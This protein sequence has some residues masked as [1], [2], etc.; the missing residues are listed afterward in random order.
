MFW[1]TEKTQ[2]AMSC[3]THVWMVCSNRSFFNMLRYEAILTIGD[4]HS[5]W[6]AQNM[7]ISIS[8]HTRKK[9][10]HHISKYCA[11]PL[12]FWHH[13]YFFVYLDSYF[14]TVCRLVL[15]IQ[16]SNIVFKMQSDMQKWM[17]P[18][19]YINIVERSGMMT[20]SL[21]LCV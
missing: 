16:T 3:R 5:V 7:L 2:A 8:E 18:A 4:R 17:P 13:A 19:N 1:V 21:L 15:K 10:H 20:S 9:Y 6:I 11:A 14:K 12:C